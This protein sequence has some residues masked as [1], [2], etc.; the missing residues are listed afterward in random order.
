M[1]A[2]RQ[3][4]HQDLAAIGERLGAIG[5]RLARIEGALGPARPD[6]SE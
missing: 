1:G 5:E 3:E 2:L 6:P 4:L